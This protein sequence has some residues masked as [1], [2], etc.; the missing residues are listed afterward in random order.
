[1]NT[2]NIL[3]AFLEQVTQ[4]GDR[5]AVIAQE[6]SVTYQELA[7]RAAAVANYLTPRVSQRLSARRWH[8]CVPAFMS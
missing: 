8:C 7:T 6:E 3:D 2:K 1:M 4:F 5:I